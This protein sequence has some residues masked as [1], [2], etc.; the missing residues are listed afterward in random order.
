MGHVIMTIPNTNGRARTLYLTIGVSGSGKSTWAK[1]KQLAAPDRIR[2][3]TMDDWRFACGSQFK[4]ADEK[5]IKRAN[6]FF[7]RQWLDAGYDV[8][9]AD[10]N[11]SAR[12]RRR[13]AEVA[14]TCS[15]SGNHVA[16][17]EVWFDDVSLETCL[18]RV[19][20]RVSEGGHDVPADAIRSQYEN[21]E[22]QI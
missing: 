22:R 4:D 9:V 18:A 21:L 3:V 2:I 15:N 7:I 20:Q 1:A 5:V 8:I 19:Q 11:L 12:N 10:T 16:V 6:E 13:W 14:K 17:E